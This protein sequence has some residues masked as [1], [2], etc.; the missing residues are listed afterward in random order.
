MLQD[1]RCHKDILIRKK[2][3][4]DRRDA[5]VLSELL[6]VNRIPLLDSKPVRGLRQV[7]IVS[8]TDQENR[9][10]TTLPN[11]AGGVRTRIINDIKQILRPTICKWQTPTKTFSTAAAIAWLKGLVL[12]DIHRLEMNHLL[13][14]L[15][16][17]EKR[18]H[19]LEQM[20][21][22]RWAVSNEVSIL[23]WVVALSPTT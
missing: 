11:E 21:A 10:L 19:E 20:I 16:Q 6:W 18:L 1:Y 17:V 7:E 22:Q 4:T 23:L 9:R 2:R 15:E 12:A 14:D 8:T 13:S 3:K 5:A